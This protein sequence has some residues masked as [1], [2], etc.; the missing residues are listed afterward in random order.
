MVRD[1]ARV[2]GAPTLTTERL[3]LRAHRIADLPACVAM[4]QDVEVVRH[5]IGSPSPP[6]RTWLRLL[7][8]AGHWSLLGFGYWA[9]E[10]TESGAFLGEIGFADFKRDLHPALDDVPEVGW[11]LAP[12]AHGKGYATEALRAA[13]AWGDEAFTTDHTVCIIYPENTA[14]LRV[15]A[16]LG[17]AEID[18]ILV[19]GQ[20]PELVL[21]RPRGERA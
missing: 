12:Q 1:E 13:I 8:Y 14:S 15:A 21:A 16:K 7:S 5:T 20:P 4:W 6:S 10:H 2:S 19:E 11:V 3:T 18:R 17:Y 9:L